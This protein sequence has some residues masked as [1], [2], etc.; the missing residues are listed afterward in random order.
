MLSNIR[1]VVVRL[2]ACLTH[3]RWMLDR[4]EFKPCKRFPLFL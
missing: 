2:L 1:G 4:R 3:N